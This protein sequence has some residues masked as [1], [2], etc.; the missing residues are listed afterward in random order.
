VK[1]GRGKRE[2]GRGKSE[3]GRRKT[4]EGSPKKEDGRPKTEDRSEKMVMLSGVEAWKW[5]DEVPSC[6]AESKHEREKLNN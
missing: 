4:E 3:E 2:E 1:E 5:E 6:W